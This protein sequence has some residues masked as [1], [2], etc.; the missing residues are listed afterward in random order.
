M[1]KRLL[2]VF[3]LLSLVSFTGCGGCAGRHNEIKAN[4]GL[5]GKYAGNYIVI[6]QDGGLIMD[7]WILEDVFVE[8]EEDS[9]G[10][11]FT[12]QDDHSTHVGGGVKTIRLEDGEDSSKWH[13]YHM[14]FE[15]QTY[16]E[17]FNS[18]PDGIED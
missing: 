2:M 15:T 11:R 10:W 9:D 12:D 16:R 4:G 14:E 1:M 7:C 18:V 3:C 6:S 8:S 13:E 17:K 5:W